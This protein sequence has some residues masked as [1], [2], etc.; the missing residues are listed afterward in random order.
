MLLVTEIENFNIEKYNRA[1][2]SRKSA[3][4][5]HLC[6]TI[7]ILTSSSLHYYQS[8]PFILFLLFLFQ[9]PRP[10]LQKQQFP[11]PHISPSTSSV[12]PSPHDDGSLVCGECGKH[13][14]TPLGYKDHMNM[15]Q[16]IFRHQCQYCNKYFSSMSG[17]KEHM[18]KHTQENYFQCKICRQKFS[19]RY[20]LK[21]HRMTEHGLAKQKMWGYWLLMVLVTKWQ[22]NS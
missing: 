7:I 21:K 6:F 17:L 19:S 9:F 11:N 2:S 14:K 12:L 4:P 8:R 20:T 16:G 3:C 18:T 5:E 1:S 10:S 13:F 15:H 22:R